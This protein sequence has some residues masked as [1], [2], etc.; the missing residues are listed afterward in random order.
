MFKGSL[1]I[2]RTLFFGFQGLLSAL[3]ENTLA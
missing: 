3:V 1:M 2:K